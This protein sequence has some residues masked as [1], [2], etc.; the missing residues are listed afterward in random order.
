MTLAAKFVGNH[1]LLGMNLF[2]FAIVRM[3]ES[4]P[5]PVGQSVFQPCFPTLSRSGTICVQN[6]FALVRCHIAAM[7]RHMHAS[8]CEITI[9]RRTTRSVRY[10]IASTRCDISFMLRLTA[11]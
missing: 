6:L 5:A 8:R 3:W 4:L 2:S 7:H 10:H 11:I 1:R 9:G